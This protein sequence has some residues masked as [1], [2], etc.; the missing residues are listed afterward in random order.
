MKKGLLG[1]S[2]AALT[3]FTFVIRGGAEETK[4]EST[5]AA[6]AEVKPEAKPV[7]SLEDIKNL[8]GMSIYFPGG[9][10]F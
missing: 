3:M 10:H 2:L 1:M 9:I 4:P 8:L 6:K 7:T 5:P